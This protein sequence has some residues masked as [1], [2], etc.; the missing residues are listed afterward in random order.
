MSEK[1][2]N[3]SKTKANRRRENG[4]ALFSFPPAKYQAKALMEPEEP[5]SFREGEPVPLVYPK[6]QPN[7]MF[8]PEI[9]FQIWKSM[10]H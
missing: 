10:I 6:G 5:V 8:S 3:D 9:S 7:S 2:K 1:R 4:R